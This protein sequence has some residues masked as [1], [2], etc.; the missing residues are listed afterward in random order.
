MELLVQAGL[1]LICLS[2]I[3]VIISVLI[4]KSQERTY[5]RLKRRHQRDRADRHITKMEVSLK[6]LEDRIVHL[7]T[8]VL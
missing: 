1:A 2:M 6:N 4:T 7:E 3:T 5:R 8:K